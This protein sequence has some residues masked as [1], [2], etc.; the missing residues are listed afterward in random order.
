MAFADGAS[1]SCL[2]GSGGDGVTEID[3]LCSRR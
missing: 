2:G 3:V 1:S